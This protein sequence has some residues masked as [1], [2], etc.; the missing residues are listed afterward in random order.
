MALFDEEKQN[1]QL[2]E[3]HKQEEEQLVASLAESKY[4]L[5]YIFAKRSK[6]RSYYRFRDETE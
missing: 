6:I 1:K 3:L 5:P 4:S 2:D